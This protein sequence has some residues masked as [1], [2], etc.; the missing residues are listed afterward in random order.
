MAAETAFLCSQ[1]DR[2]KRLIT[3]E[4]SDRNGSSSTRGIALFEAACFDLGQD[5]EC[6]DKGSE[7]VVVTSR[8]VS[9]LS[10][11]ITTLAS[12]VAH[13]I[14]IDGLGKLVF[15]DR[16]SWVCF[17]AIFEGSEV[18][19]EGSRDDHGFTGVYRHYFIPYEEKGGG[20]V[21]T[22]EV[23]ISN[24]GDALDASQGGRH[25]VNANPKMVIRLSSGKRAVI[26]LSGGW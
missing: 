14:G 5:G 2:Q 6:A 7:T 13:I 3:L 1:R 24:L 20:S 11:R 9:P 21:R 17:A 25:C 23:H 22:G 4:F 16:S 15:L 12:N 10:S 18:A 8:V 26:G 19:A